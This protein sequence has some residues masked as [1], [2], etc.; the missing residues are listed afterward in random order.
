MVEGECWVLYILFG[1]G[2]DKAR[3]CVCEFE[4][5]VFVTSAR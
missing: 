5:K 3:V 1:F 4:Y 2:C